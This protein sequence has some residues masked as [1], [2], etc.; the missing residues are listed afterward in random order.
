MF[1]NLEK[2]RSRKTFV[3]TEFWIWIV[4][5]SDQHTVGISQCHCGAEGGTPN[6]GIPTSTVNHKCTFWFEQ[7]ECH[8][9]KDFILQK[10]SPLT[11][12]LAWFGWLT[13]VKLYS[14]NVFWCSGIKH[15]WI[16]LKFHI[17]KQYDNWFSFLA[18]LNAY[19]LS[20]KIF[21]RLICSHFIC[22]VL[23]HSSITLLL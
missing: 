17:M 21:I 18:W 4:V 19:K 3:L 9:M 12:L 5:Y 23:T 11:I 6:Q 1:G 22:L 16:E 8:A 14:F 15:Y 20:P 2:E 13:T 7:C 10:L